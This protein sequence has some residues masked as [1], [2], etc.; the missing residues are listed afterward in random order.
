MV[1]QGVAGVE[2]GP[3]PAVGHS[4]SPGRA[5]CLPSMHTWGSGRRS[6]SCFINNKAG[7]GRNKVSP[8]PLTLPREAAGEAG[9][10]V[11]SALHYLRDHIP[12]VTRSSSPG[13]RETLLLAARV[14]HGRAHG[15][16]GRQ[17]SSPQNDIK[18]KERATCLYSNQD[19]LGFR[20]IKASAAGF[21]PSVQVGD[22]AVTR[23]GSNLKK[24]PLVFPLLAPGQHL[25]RTLA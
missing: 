2:E 5:P 21:T 20:G 12:F 13:I 7:T 22:V 18:S 3:S 19:A 25:P 10:C 23:S 17:R 8:P 14:A 15:W 9:S 6:P 24:P 4:L 16:G 11:S 1:V